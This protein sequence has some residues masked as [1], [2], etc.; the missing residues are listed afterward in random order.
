MGSTAD[1]KLQKRSV[2]LKMW[3]KNYANLTERKKLQR[4]SDLWANN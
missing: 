1:Y 2:N 3:N 4:F